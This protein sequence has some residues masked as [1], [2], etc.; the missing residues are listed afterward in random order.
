MKTLQNSIAR[1]NQ[2]EIQRLVFLKDKSNL[3]LTK[4]SKSLATHLNSR[5]INHYQYLSVF[6]VVGIF[7][8]IICKS[9]QNIF[10]NSSYLKLQHSDLDLHS[11]TWKIL[12]FMCGL[13]KPLQ[14]SLNDLKCQEKLQFSWRLKKEMMLLRE[15]AVNTELHNKKESRFS[16]MEWLFFL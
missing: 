4:Y 14:R 7:F 5:C 16:F 15:E 1:G 10:P 11:M 13:H 12:C 9:K 2:I 8:N 6:W 3:L